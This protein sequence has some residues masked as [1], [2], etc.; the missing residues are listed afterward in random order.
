M[1]YARYGCI[2][3]VIF[4][5]KQTSGQTPEVGCFRCSWLQGWFWSDVFRI[6]AYISVLFPIHL[7]ESNPYLTERSKKEK[8]T[9]SFYF[10]FF[11]RF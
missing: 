10:S 4:D 6:S 11:F 5:W 9:F 3:P 8:P 2:A 7:L 1:Q